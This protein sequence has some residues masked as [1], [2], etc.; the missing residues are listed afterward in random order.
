[1]F[2]AV[3]QQVSIK[4]DRSLLKDADNS[5][6]TKGKVSNL[7]QSLHNSACRTGGKVKG[8]VFTVST[9]KN[10]KIQ[11]QGRVKETKGKNLVILMEP[12][13]MAPTIT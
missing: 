13:S 8:T 2:S 9:K 12:T 6:T 4:L 5:G 1:V 3:F 7:I 10:G 11:R